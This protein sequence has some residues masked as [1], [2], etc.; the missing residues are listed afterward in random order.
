MTSL[1]TIKTLVMAVQTLKDIEQLSVKDEIKEQLVRKVLESIGIIET[2]EGETI[3]APTTENLRLKQ[4]TLGSQERVFESLSRLGGSATR[5]DI[6]S[7]SGLDPN[8]VSSLLNKL[9]KRNRL[10][11]VKIDAVDSN[12]NR[13]G[14]GLKPG[15]IYKLV[16]KENGE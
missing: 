6:A 2:V 9:V 10:E 13:N 7:D 1:Q 16:D 15:Y 4:P 11:K 8:I 5:A 12:S 14:R 3:S